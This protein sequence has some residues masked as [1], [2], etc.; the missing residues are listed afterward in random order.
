MKMVDKKKVKIILFIISLLLISMSMVL[1][2]SIWNNRSLFFD[3]HVY[4]RI[5]Y[6]PYVKLIYEAIKN[7]DFTNQELSDYSYV[8]YNFLIDDKWYTNLPDDSNII[9]NKK[10]ISVYVKENINNKDFLSRSNIRYSIQDESHEKMDEIL[11]EG[12]IYIDMSKNLFGT[13]QFSIGHNLKLQS[14]LYF[15]C[16]F[17]CF[18]VYWIDFIP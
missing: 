14:L 7:D 1:S 12:Y 9:E 13:L 6:S 11:V 18:N 2:I 5:N 15:D 17:F 8:Y 3:E 16:C 10:L 4:G